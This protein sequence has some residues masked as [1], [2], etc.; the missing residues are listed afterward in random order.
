MVIYHDFVELDEQV[1]DTNEIPEMDDVAVDF[2]LSK[3]VENLH[4]IR[5]Q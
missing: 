3:L 4:S 1:E 5:H 2:S